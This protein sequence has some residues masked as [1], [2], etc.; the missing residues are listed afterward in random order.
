MQKLTVSISEQTKLYDIL[1]LQDFNEL[2]TQLLKQIGT[3]KFLVITDEN[4]AHHIPV[5]E[6]HLPH[7]LILPAGEAHK[8]W[9]GIEKILNYGFEHDFD[10]SCVFVALGGGVIGDMVGFAASLYM[11]GLPFI[12][13][14]TT[15]LSMVD[16]SVGGKTGIDCEYGK[17]L[18][19]AFHQPETIYC[20]E[21]FLKTLPEAEVKNG[22]AEMIKHGI[23]G[24]R[25]HFEHLK[26]LIS[27]NSKFQVP[28]SKLFDLVPESIEI[29]K[30]IVE[31]DEQEQGVRMHLN[32]GH[33]F[34]H[35]IE[36]LS[37]YEIAH[38]QAVAMGTVMAAEYALKKGVCSK[39]TYQ[40]IRAIFED[41]GF[42]LTIPYEKE[43]IFE[44]MQ[45]DK[46]KRGGKINLV[47]PEGIG[48]V[49]V[50]PLQDNEID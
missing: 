44:A 45:H 37:T 20:C 28:S 30:K 26:D 3:R 24:S 14:P 40:E 31:A 17:N 7:F 19:G 33:T 34:G 12:Q 16:A 46:K 4:V 6:L 2:L 43:R 41:F 1:F 18:I 38:G 11:R 15:L 29:K 47:L 50:Y 36:L 39:A 42:N 48:K 10:R 23:L 9:E 49:R 21:D 32:L 5:K 27:P 22:I 25:D 35:A 8:N 13:I